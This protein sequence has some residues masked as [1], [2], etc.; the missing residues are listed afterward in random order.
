MFF[1]IV[2]PN[3]NSEEYIEK[4]LSSIEEQTFKDFSIIIIDDS[5]T[6]NSLEMIKKYK[7]KYNNIII[8]TPKKKVWNGGGRNI[9]LKYSSEYTLFLDCDDWFNSNDCL[10]NIYN[11]IIVNNYPDCVRL[12]YNLVMGEQ[13]IPVTL[14]E[15]NPKD[16][17]NSIYIAPWT[18]CLKS[19]IIVQFPENTLVEDVSWHIEQCDK[20]KSISVCD[21][22]I[23][24]WNRNN[25]NSISINDGKTTQ[26][27]K[28]KSSIFR[29]L[30][31][32]M[33]L[34]LEHDYCKENRDK[35][36]EAYLD[37]FKKEQYITF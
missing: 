22:P 9:G 4:C 23:V 31:D 13:I 14:K 16:L 6:D 5:S 11:N 28:R 2:I 30:A 19:S 27:I 18:T 25:I 17:T 8:E 21:I 10:E 24:C 36:I 26:L 35:R 15:N 3:Y 12:S 29:C 37:S 32:L 33:D 1:K 7:N 20:I 34:E